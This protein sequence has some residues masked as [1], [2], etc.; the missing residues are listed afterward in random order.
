[1]TT[2]RT[3]YIIIRHLSVHLKYTKKGYILTP[4]TLY[5]LVQMKIRKRKGR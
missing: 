1:M 5:I 3:H 4:M 2:G